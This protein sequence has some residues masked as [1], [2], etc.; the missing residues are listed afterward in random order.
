MNI[1]LRQFM[2]ISVEAI[3]PDSCIVFVRKEDE[4]WGTVDE[5]VLGRNEWSPLGVTGFNNIGELDP[6]LDYEVINFNQE[7]QYGE[8]FG[9][10]ITLRE[11]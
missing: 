1:T 11:V 10:Y 4:D 7:F 9:Q 6:Y 5:C 8:L 3:V 2:E